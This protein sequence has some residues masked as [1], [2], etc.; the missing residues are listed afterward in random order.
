MGRKPLYL[1]SLFGFG[2]QVLVFFKAALMIVADFRFGPQ[3]EDLLALEARSD[4]VLLVL[5]TDVPT[6]AYEWLRCFDAVERR[7][8]QRA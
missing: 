3:D 2:K 6:F 1:G 8:R 4:G 5:E 7:R